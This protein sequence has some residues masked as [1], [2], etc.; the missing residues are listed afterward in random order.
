[1]QLYAARIVTGLPIIASKE[2]SYFETGWEPLCDRKKAKLIT[3]YQLHAN[4][5]P[6]DLCDTI[7]NFRKMH[8]LILEM[9]KNI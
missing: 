7:A 9:R 1:M 4:T 5:E 2:S 6:Q 3:M 8:N